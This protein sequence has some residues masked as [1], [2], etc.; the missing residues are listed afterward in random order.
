MM[1]EEEEEKEEKEE[2][3]DEEDEED[4]EEE[5]EDEEDEEATSPAFVKRVTTRRTL[6]RISL[7]SCT[8]MTACGS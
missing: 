1:V 2:K 4:E 3:E 8:F 6:I 5:D 7:C